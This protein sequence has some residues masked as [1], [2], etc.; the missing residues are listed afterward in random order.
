MI[1]QWLRHYTLNAG[2]PRLITGQGTRSIMPQIKSY[3][4]QVKTLY[5]ATKKESCVLQLRPGADKYIN[6]FLKFGIILGMNTLL[7]ITYYSLL[8]NFSIV[9]MLL[10]CTVYI[11]LFKKKKEEKYKRAT[12]LYE[13]R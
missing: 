13:S 8:L 5:A 7:Y 10:L 6:I 1:V 12:M 4:L 9:I 11:R 2:D 3:I